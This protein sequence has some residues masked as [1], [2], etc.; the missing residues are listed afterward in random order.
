MPK[1]NTED[2]LARLKKGTTIPALLLLGAEPYL[3]DACRAALIDAYVPEASRPW[4]VSRYSADQGETQA[5]L[6]QAQTMPMLCPRQVV[7]LEDAEMIEKLAE[8]KR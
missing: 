8:A 7:F 3:R 5:A 2:L 1:S 4:A 6:E